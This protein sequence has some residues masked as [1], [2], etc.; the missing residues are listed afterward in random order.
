MGAGETSPLFR[1]DNWI[2]P[3]GDEIA[4]HDL[5]IEEWKVDEVSNA[6]KR[7]RAC[8]QAGG[9]FGLFPKRLAAYF[10]R[11]H[12]FEPE[13]ENYRCLVANLEGVSNVIHGRA[14][15]GA[16][17][18]RVGLKGQAS[19]AGAWEVTPKGNIPMIALDSL[20]LDDCDLIYLDIEGYEIEALKGARETLTRC[21]P[22]VVVEDKGVGGQL[23]GSVVAWLENNGYR[24][25]KRLQKD[26]WCT[27]EN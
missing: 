14:A 7:R 19:N 23:A 3:T 12:T 10:E 24:F 11:V 2:F 20:A 17:Q 5:F 26:Y 15:L 27:P 22:H 9:N 13:K 25:H 1:M 16:R 4:R 8:I 6:L 18:G 21:W